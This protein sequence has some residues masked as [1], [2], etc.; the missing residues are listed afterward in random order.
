MINNNIKEEIISHFAKC[1]EDWQQFLVVIHDITSDT[2]EYHYKW[3]YLELSLFELDCKQ[4]SGKW[5]A[6]IFDTK[7]SINEQWKEIEVDKQKAL[8]QKQ[9]VNN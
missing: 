3:D 2:Y 5:E 4:R 9:A 1:K 6:F 8:R 7:R